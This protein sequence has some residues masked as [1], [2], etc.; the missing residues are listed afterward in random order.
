MTDENT[1]SGQRWLPGSEITESIDQDTATNLDG[2]VLVNN[3]G[4]R[5]QISAADDSVRLTVEQGHQFDPESQ[6]WSDWEKVDTAT[7][8][9]LEELLLIVAN[10]AADLGSTS[11]LSP[12]ELAALIRTFAR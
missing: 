8:T 5:I 11:S 3:R 4:Y 2:T 9:S 10:R 6:T 7:A 1:D 12:S